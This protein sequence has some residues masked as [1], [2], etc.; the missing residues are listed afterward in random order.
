MK[1]PSRFVK[2]L[3]KTR[4]TLK[5]KA[6][7]RGTSVIKQLRYRIRARKK[8]VLWHVFSFFSRLEY[9]F[10]YGE[11]FFRFQIIFVLFEKK[12]ITRDKII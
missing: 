6:E 5:K 12:V 8:Y 9:D 7:K 11:I 1:F 3:K 10:F 4:E 2:L